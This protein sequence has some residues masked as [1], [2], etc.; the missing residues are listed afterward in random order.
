MKKLK[1]T[2]SEIRKVDDLDLLPI[3]TKEMIRE[4]FTD[5]QSL[6][7]LHLRVPWATGGSTGEPLKFFHDKKGLL[8]KNAN[9]IRFFN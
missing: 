3:L 7:H 6:K 1:L 9:T 5:L 4:N 8:Y 2:P